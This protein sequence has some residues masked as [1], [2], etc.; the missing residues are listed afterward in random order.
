MQGL[1]P[2]GYEQ[3]VFENLSG[4]IEGEFKS[5]VSVGLI[6][7]QFLMRGLTAYSGNHVM[8]LGDLLSWYY[9]SLA[10]IQTDKS[11]VGF[12]KIILKPIFP[13]GLDF[14]KASHNSPYGLIISEWNRVG[15]VINWKITI[16]ANTTAAIGLSTY[17]NVSIDGKP[18][19]DIDKL[20]A[21]LSLG[22]GEYEIAVKL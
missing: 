19:S 7:I 18:V 13:A 12:K 14:V 3:K 11:E 17:K 22:S 8:L 4:R 9:E 1:V 10:G 21:L 2:E 5:H 16:P 15:D 6:G 20:G